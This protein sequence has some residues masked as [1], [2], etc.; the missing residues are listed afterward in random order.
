DLRSRWGVVRPKILNILQATPFYPW[1]P[2][3]AP[4]ELRRIDEAL[5]KDVWYLRQLAR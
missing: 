2:S 4:W 3:V 5:Q 1:L